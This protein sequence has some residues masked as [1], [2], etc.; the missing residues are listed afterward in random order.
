MLQHSNSDKLI[1]YICEIVSTD[2]IFMKGFRLIIFFLFVSNAV[3]SQKKTDNFLT[4]DTD[5]I[6]IDSTNSK[7]IFNKFSLE[8]GTGISNGTRPYTDQF[9]TSVNNQLF[10]GFIFNSFMVGAKYN[11]SEI[12]GFKMDLA[13]DRFINSEQTKSKPFEVAQYRTSIQAVFN[14]NSFVKPI[15]YV[16]RFNLFFRGG[17]Q[18]AILKPIAADYNIK[19]SNGDSYAG[20]VFGITPTIRISKKT[21]VF[22]DLSSYS[23]YGQNITWNGKHSA[24]SNNS[25]GHMYS[26]TIGLSF[27]LD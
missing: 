6:K 17:I 3:F 16:S 11:F 24:T 25:E 9:Y 20:I 15:N 27:A 2:I 26:G 23:N 4:L 8:I 10:N 22:L 5:S 21:S 18:L 19:V 13:F 12:V 1:K 7:A 14:L